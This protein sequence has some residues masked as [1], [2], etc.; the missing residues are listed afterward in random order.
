MERRAD[1]RAAPPAITSASL[2]D[3]DQPLRRPGRSE[4][5]RAAADQRRAARRVRRGR[6]ARPGVLLP[7][8]PDRSPRQPHPVPEARRLRPEAIRAARCASSTPAGA[9]RSRSSTRSRTARPTPTTT[10]RSAPTTSASTTTIP[11]R[12]TSAAARSSRSTRAIR[13]AG[14]T[15]SPTIRACRRTCRRRC[16]AGACRR[17]SSQD[18]GGWPHQIYVREARRMIGTFVM[19]ENELLKQRPTP[20]S[21]GMGSYSIDS[22]N[23]QRYI[24]PEGYVQNEGDIGV[25]DQRP[26]RDRLRLAGAEARPGDNLLVPVCRLQLAHRLRLDPHGAGVHD[27][28]P[29]GR[30]RRGLWRSTAAPR[31]RMSLTRGSGSGCSRMGKSSRRNNCDNPYVGASRCTKGTKTR[32]ATKDSF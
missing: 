15:S 26:V 27:P 13:R 8:V 4:E 22:H 31:C 20:D 6:Q 25:A 17:T 9:R 5:R 30:H 2:N 18:N 19:T 16:D 7:H 24:T 12:P 21:V 1:R 3:E 14:S 10:A 11:R 23:V 28:R 29:V 32:R